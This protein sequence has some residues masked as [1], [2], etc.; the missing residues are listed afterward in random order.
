MGKSV[1]SQ[2]SSL[3]E[4]TEGLTPGVSAQRFRGVITI[5]KSE[6]PHSGQITLAVHKQL[7]TPEGIIIQ[8]FIV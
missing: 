5:N 8:S 1:H 3:N 2:F 4:Q 6:R 7:Q